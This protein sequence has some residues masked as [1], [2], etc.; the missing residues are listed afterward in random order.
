M[1][2]LRFSAVAVTGT[3]PGP[4]SVVTLAHDSGETEEEI[5]RDTEREME[6]EGKVA[7]SAVGREGEFLV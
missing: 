7:K 4:L 2:W 6:G 1:V 3:T 5:E